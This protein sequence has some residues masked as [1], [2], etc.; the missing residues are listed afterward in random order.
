MQDP[1]PAQSITRLAQALGI[2]PRLAERLHDAGI[3]RPE[4]F[5]TRPARELLLIRGIGKAALARMKSAVRAWLRQTVEVRSTDTGP[6][7][8]A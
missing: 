1:H 8:L 2:G 3:T 5:A 7:R 6:R 4:D